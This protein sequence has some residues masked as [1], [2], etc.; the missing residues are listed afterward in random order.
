MPSSSQQMTAL[1]R[2]ALTVLAAL[3]SMRMLGLFMILPVLPLYIG[4]IPGATPVA[5][6][7]AIGAYG[8]S[9]ALLQYPFGWL[10]DRYGRRALL[11]VG[12]GLFIAGS[13]LAALSQTIIGIT[14]GRLLQGSGAIA[15]VLLA[16]LG[17]QLRAPQRMAGMAVIGITIGASFLAALILGPLLL[18]LG[19]LQA[20]FFTNAALGLLGFVLVLTLL[21]GSPPTPDS[22]PADPDGQGAVQSPAGE[23]R[24]M[25]GWCGVACSIH[26]T[27]TAAF[28][29]IPGILWQ[30]LGYAP[31]SHWRLYAIVLPLSA[32]PMLWLAYWRRHPH[33]AL[34]PAAMLSSALALGLLALA[35][36]ATLPGLLLFFVGFNLLEATLPA[37]MTQRAPMTRRGAA[38]GLFS[39]AQFLGAFG[40]GLLGGIALQW[41]GTEAPFA[42]GAVLLGCWLPWLWR[43]AKAP[44]DSAGKMTMART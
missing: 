36:T 44:T 15:G 43:N 40:G 30:Q 26:L 3:Y 18:P 5:V 12:L 8:L 39:S 23:R 25:L 4:R 42:L 11:L 34:L 35:P 22:T 33:P 19:G 21:P 20:V 32:L 29:A 41:G 31:S 1:E 9:Q 10:S 13:V 2:R 14:A 28:V 27:L 17:D 7:L 6:G 37:M 24:S 38:L 16:C